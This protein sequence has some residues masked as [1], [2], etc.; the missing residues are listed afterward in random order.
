MTWE[1]F[2]SAPYYDIYAQHVLASGAVDPA[3]PTDGRVLCAAAENQQNPAIVTDGAGGAI[4]T[5]EDFRSAHNYDIYAQHV[6]AG[7]AAD[8]A[9]PADGRALCTA[10]QDQT[11][12]TTIEDGAGGAIVA[13]EDLRSGAEA[14]IYAQRVQPNGELGGD[15]TPA[16]LS[17]VS[18]EAD[19]R[20]VRLKWFAGGT[21]AMVASVYRRTPDSAWLAVASLS[22]DGSGFMN[23]DDRA[24]ERGTRYG[25]RLGV[26]GPKG[27]EYFGEI[28]L[29]VPVGPAFSLEELRP[30]P[31]QRDLIVA[32]SLATAGAA[33]VELV[34][35]SGRIVARYRVDSKPG[36]HVIKLEAGTAPAAGLYLVRLVQGGR[37]AARKACIVH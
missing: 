31:A 17:L 3:W 34:D 11:R 7:G 13:W 30:N 8:P 28:W 29:M 12:P 16:L 27:E 5:W 20:G 10:T 19:E 23:Y 35:L 15:V 9:W 24:V 14:D 26:A 1:D 32:Y 18:V 36:S 4:V 21:I 25:Y 6:L 22:P 2:R 37:S 33:A